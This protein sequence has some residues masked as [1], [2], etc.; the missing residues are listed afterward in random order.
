MQYK[1]EDL[2]TWKEESG[3]TI[4]QIAEKSGVPA[5]TLGKISI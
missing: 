4:V 3:L 2:I 5:G 1:R